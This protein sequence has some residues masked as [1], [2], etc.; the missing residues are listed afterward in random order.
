M[1]TLLLGGTGAMGGYLQRELVS[2]GW[3]VYVTLRSARKSEGRGRPMP[4][5]KRCLL[6]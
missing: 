1:R 6:C 2:L 5:A 4:F 3:E